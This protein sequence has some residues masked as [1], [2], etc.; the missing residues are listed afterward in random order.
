[1]SGTW[2][3][4]ATAAETAWIIGISMWLLFE[5]RSPIATIAWILALALMPLVGLVVYYVIGPRRFNRKKLRREVARQAARQAAT[6]GAKADQ[7]LQAAGVGRFV[8]L[9]E[10]ASGEAGVP[11]AARVELYFAGRDAY[12]AILAAIAGA[13]HHVHLEYYIWEPDNIGTRMRDAL[14]ARARAGVEVRVLVD[15]FGSAACKR[16]FWAPLVEAGGQV[17][18]FNALTPRRL[19]PRLANFRTHRKIVVVDGAIGFTGGINVSDV[20]TSEF[21]GDAAWR[22]T[23][24]RLEGDAVRGLQLVF[25]EGWHDVCDQVLEGPAYFPA[26]HPPS[27]EDHL[28]QVMASGP[29]ENYDVIQRLFVAAAG[30]ARRRVLLTAPYFVPDAPLFTALT[31]AALAG[32][33]VRVLTPAEND[34]RLVGAASRSYYPDLLECGVRLFEYGPPMLHA[35]TLVVDDLLAIVGTA[36]ADARSFRLNFEVVVVCYQPDICE[37]LA[38]AFAGDLERSVEI[39]GAHVAGYGFGTR[40][41]QNFARVFSPTL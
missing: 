4:V 41:F 23:H 31:T 28:V 38:D 1:M 16:S 8:H 27:A 33:D 10:A 40:L 12:A 22:D 17:K 5:R 29:D 26:P 34:L 3:L 13:G 35:K 15:G 32:V 9:G 20:H 24:A 39:D 7:E 37:L 14:V 18:K 25:C 30:A 11:R 6:L 2:W 36:N 19:R 21:S